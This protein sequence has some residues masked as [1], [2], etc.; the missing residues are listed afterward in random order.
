MIILKNYSVVKK[1][2][3]YYII[4]KKNSICPKCNN[5]LKVHD[6][7]K[8][9]IIS[10][11]GKVY[12]FKLRRLKCKNCKTLHIELPDIIIPYKKYSKDAI[13][14]ALFNKKT[15][16]YAENSTIYRWKKEY[17]NNKKI[18]DKISYINNF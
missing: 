16:C 18:M 17:L 1:N 10:I 7:K 12:V 11:D 14:S 5:I 6:N 3:Y 8:R 2:D 4:S 13:E 15:S 9:K